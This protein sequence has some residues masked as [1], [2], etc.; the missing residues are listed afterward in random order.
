[1]REKAKRNPPKHDTK[2]SPNHFPSFFMY[3]CFLVTTCPSSSLISTVKWSPFLS[4]FRGLFCNSPLNERISKDVGKGSGKGRRCSLNNCLNDIQSTQLIF[5]ILHKSFHGLLQR[6]SFLGIVLVGVSSCPSNS[7][8]GTS[9]LYAGSRGSSASCGGLDS[10]G[11][12]GSHRRV[13][14]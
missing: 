8:E 1:M 6:L 5:A 4:G 13:H 2:V 3:T 11:S 9:E 7:S 12:W 10:S 14:W